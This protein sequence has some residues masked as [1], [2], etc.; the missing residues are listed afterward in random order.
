MP[1]PADPVPPPVR[2]QPP[3]PRSA[4]ARWLLALAGV[5]AVDGL[6]PRRV[7]VLLPSV[8]ASR[9]RSLRTPE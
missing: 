4:T 2:R 8:A 1:K 9:R 6:A 3:P 7:P 5:V